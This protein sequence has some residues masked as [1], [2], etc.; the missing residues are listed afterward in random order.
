MI[1]KRLI[2]PERLRQIPPTF[3]WI[4]HRLARLNLLSRCS[5]GALALYLFLL[6]V[7][8]AQGLSYYSA[9]AICRQVNFTAEE[10]ARVRQELIQADLIAF[11]K[12]LYQVLS[13]D[14]QTSLPF[15][16]PSERSGQTQSAAD[17]LR[18]MLQSTGGAL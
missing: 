11:Q 17:I 13:L 18:R 5:H 2:R 3:S 14:P 9:K 12:P 7:A 1:V 10:L 4:D 15:I 16:E 8:D 6:T